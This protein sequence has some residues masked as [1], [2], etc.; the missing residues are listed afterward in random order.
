M[1][2]RTFFYPQI[3]L[4]EENP[5]FPWLAQVPIS[6]FLSIY[7]L[8]KIKEKQA[9]AELGQAQIKLKVSSNRF[10][11]CCIKLIN[12]NTAGYFDCH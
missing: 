2:L 3:W 4:A 6:N 8:A 9:G 10:K 1:I 12:K 11:I 7:F 5:L